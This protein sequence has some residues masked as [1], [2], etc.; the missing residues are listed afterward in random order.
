MGLFSS[1]NGERSFDHVHAALGNI[2]IFLEDWKHDRGTIYCS[3][4]YP[5]EYLL[6]M[7]ISQ[8]QDAKA[9]Y[10][11]ECRKN[12]NINPPREPDPKVDMETALRHAMGNEV[13]DCSLILCYIGQHPY[14]VNEFLSKLDPAVHSPLG[15]TAA[16]RYTWQR[17]MDLSNWKPLLKR[18][19]AYYTDNQMVGEDPK[20]L[21]LGLTQ[22]LD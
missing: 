13:E 22:F 1:S 7:A 17:E 5:N 12:P 6:A 20:D 4:D 8:L 14:Q 18:A 21:F 2:E 16:L 10:R 15:L 19:F 11:E 3:N 9:K